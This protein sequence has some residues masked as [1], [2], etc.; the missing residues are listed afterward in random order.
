MADDKS[1]RGPADRKRISLTEDYE[2][3][4]WCGRFGC[5]EEDLR[6]AVAKV[7]HMATDVEGYFG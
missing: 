1:K 3:R 6:E 7:G 4:Y 5:S 2:V